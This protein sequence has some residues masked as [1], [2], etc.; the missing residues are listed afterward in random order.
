MLSVLSRASPTRMAGLS[1][2]TMSMGH[3]GQHGQVG[4]VRDRSGVWHSPPTSSQAR[5][6]HLVWLTSPA[7]PVDNKCNYYTQCPLSLYEER[8]EDMREWMHQ[9]SSDVSAVL[10]AHT[11]GL[12]GHDCPVFGPCV[13]PV[14]GESHEMSNAVSAAPAV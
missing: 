8:N 6:F 7:R 3:H 4:L 14:L 12:F 10:P 11:C 2:L 9:L 1:S 5:P 13:A